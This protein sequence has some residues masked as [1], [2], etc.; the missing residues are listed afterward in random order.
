MAFDK[1]QTAERLREAL[2][3]LTADEQALLRRVFFDDAS[4]ATISRECGLPLGTVKSRFVR[5]L[6]KLRSA[7]ENNK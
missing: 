5:A 2:T 3:T 7:L 6:P 1:L 4:L